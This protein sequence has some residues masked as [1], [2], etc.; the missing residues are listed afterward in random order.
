MLLKD[1]FLSYKFTS[2]KFNMA[3]LN[4]LYMKIYLVQ[5]ILHYIYTFDETLRLGWILKY[6]SP[7]P[8]PRI[9]FHKWYVVTFDD[10]SFLIRTKNL[11]TIVCVFFFFL[12]VLLI[13]CKPIP[14]RLNQKCHAIK[15]NFLSLMSITLHKR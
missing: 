3:F 14:I 9:I 7:H 2:Y 6:P 15:C 1:S 8:Y 12:S 11:V 13:K 5:L 4:N 10:V